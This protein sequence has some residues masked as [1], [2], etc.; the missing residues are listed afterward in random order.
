[1]RWPRFAV[2]VLITAL[3]Q[4][5]VVDRISVTQWHIVPDLML[6]LM[7]FFAIKCN[8]EDAIISSFSIGLVA[9]IIM[10]GFPLGPR[11]IS[12]GLFGTGLAY[13]NR[14]IAIKKISHQSVAIFTI[15]F[16]SGILI[17]I[18][19]SLAGRPAWSGWFG[20]VLGS[21]I[22]SAVIGPFLFIILD[23]AMNIKSKRRGR[24]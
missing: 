4:S 6:I 1:M 17:R 16:T 3:L 8:I 22:Y 10:M 19:S 15:G 21:S 5:N 23:L 2:M 14:V 20:I 12:F 7:V 13:L 24:D 11:I 9:D 18:L